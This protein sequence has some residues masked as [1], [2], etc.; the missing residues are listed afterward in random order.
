[1]AIYI[2]Y[3]G[4]WHKVQQKLLDFRIIPRSLSQ[5][6]LILSFEKLLNSP[7]RYDKFGK[8]NKTVAVPFGLKA[9]ANDRLA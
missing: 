1:M 5:N 4:F 8:T 9:I 3:T 2:H 7:R 6:C